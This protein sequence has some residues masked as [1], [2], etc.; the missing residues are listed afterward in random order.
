MVGVDWDKFH[1]FRV[2]KDDTNVKLFVDNE[3]DASITI[4]LGDL[5]NNSV[6]DRAILATT[7]YNGQVDF[8]IRSFRYRVGTTSFGDP[9]KPD[10]TGD[11]DS[12]DNVGTSDLLILLTNWGPCSISPAACPAD[13]DSNGFVG[14]SDI[15]ILFGNW[16]PC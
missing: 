5:P 12:N 13:L 1:V 15:L 3:A 8:E 6:G 14:T 2:E 10:C 4:A 9:D 11:L 7:S 16:G